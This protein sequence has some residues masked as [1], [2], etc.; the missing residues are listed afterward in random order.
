VSSSLGPALAV[1]F[2]PGGEVVLVRT[3][4]IAEWTSGSARRIAGAPGI[5]SGGA[6]SQDG[7]H[8][9]WIVGGQITIVE[10][11]GGQT[12]TIPRPTS[13]VLRVA[14]SP[15]G[16][17]VAGTTYDAVHAW[18]KDGTFLWTSP[19]VYG[20]SLAFSPDG[21]SLWVGGYDRV[22]RL[23][24]STGAITQVDDG[25]SF[26]GWNATGGAIVYQNG[27]RAIDPRSGTPVTDTIAYDD[28]PY[29]IPDGYYAWVFGDT[30]VAHTGSGTSSCVPLEV[31]IR[32]SRK[33]RTL[34]APD[35]DT[36]HSWIGWD[37]GPGVAISRDKGG[38]L[39]WDLVTGK[40]LFR[41]PK[42]AAE[43][44]NVVFSRDASTMLV[45]Y[46]DDT[47]ATWSIAKKKK[48]ADASYRASPIVLSHDGARAF[49]WADGALEV[50]DT[51]TLTRQRLTPQPTTILELELSPDGSL[52]AAT[53]MDRVTTIWRVP[54]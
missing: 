32:N 50:V 29:D 49:A 7:S 38:P 18:K 43:M 11:S 6:V 35:C 12:T 21:R 36:E 39:V 16:Q 28:M 41:M 9:A 8:A 46:Y 31:W 22:A 45:T 5:A 53:D 19:R 10:L 23:E 25:P 40:K 44:A 42:T 24:P 20:A 2:R 1:G 54:R 3:D 4:E 47:V 27:A 15:D 52:L 26:S 37:V 51:R 33:T 17:T 34:P 48:L 13:D 14:L 30:S